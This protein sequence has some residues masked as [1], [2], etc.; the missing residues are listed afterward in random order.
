ML[1]R[2]VGVA[3]DPD[4]AA[5]ERKD[6]TDVPGRIRQDRVDVAFPED[7]RVDPAEK[8][9]PL[10][11][12]PCLLFGGFLAFQL[13]RVRL[14]GELLLQILFC[15]SGA[16]GQ[17]PRHGP[18]HRQVEKGCA[19]RRQ[20]RG[21]E[22][23]LYRT[24]RKAEKFEQDHDGDFHPGDDGQNPYEQLAPSHALPSGITESRCFCGLLDSSGLSPA[25][26]IGKHT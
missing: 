5:R 11:L 8:L 10:R 13:L 25:V 19:E 24:L 16:F 15:E 17:A 20:D 14:E 12:D 22:E 6:T 26:L 4:R 18:D 21:V 2:L 7:R 9:Q 1:G 3:E 23:I